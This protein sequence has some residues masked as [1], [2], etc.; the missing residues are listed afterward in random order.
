MD[1]KNVNVP[2]AFAVVTVSESDLEALWDVMKTFAAA[3]KSAIENLLRPGVEGI[4]FQ[5]RLTSETLFYAH[6]FET[7]DQLSVIAYS[8][9][10]PTAWKTD[11]NLLLERL[12][13]RF[14]NDRVVVKI[15]PPATA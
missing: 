9:D 11:W 5:I 4:S 7:E 15:E 2:V 12:R 6:N 8:H 1:L 3:K 10:D 13:S 14:S